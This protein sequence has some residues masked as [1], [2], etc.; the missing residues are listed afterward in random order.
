MNEAADERVRQNI[1]WAR[2]VF[3]YRVLNAHIS[4]RQGRAASCRGARRGR[5]RVRSVRPW[6][7]TASHGPN[8]HCWTQGFLE[9]WQSSYDWRAWEAKLNSLR[10]FTTTIDGI[11][12]HFVHE[13]STKPGA[14]PLLLLHGWPGSYFE[15]YKLIPM[16]QQADPGFHIVAPSLPGEG[17]GRTVAV[18]G[19]RRGECGGAPGTPSG[20]GQPPV[21]SSPP[22]VTP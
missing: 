21:G 7:L 17:R 12:L 13:P 11:D 4:A 1:V 22:A 3:L 10:Q 20:C 6:L 14:I 16:L 15:F 18:H 8:P 2:Q 5:R 9:Y 19:C